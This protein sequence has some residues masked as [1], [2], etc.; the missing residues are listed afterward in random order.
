[1]VYVSMLKARTSSD[2]EP[3]PTASRAAID[4][5]TDRF[6]KYRAVDNILASPD[7]NIST[8]RERLMIQSY[9]ITTAHD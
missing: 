5:E 8:S 1:M 6:A 3:S 7:Q 9:R 4:R 2:H